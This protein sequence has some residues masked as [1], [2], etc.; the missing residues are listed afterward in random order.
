ME[1]RTGMDRIN[2]EKERWNDHDSN[3][4]PS[5]SSRIVALSLFLSVTTMKSM[6]GGFSLSLQDGDNHR[7]ISRMTCILR[8]EKTRSDKTSCTE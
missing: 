5:F 3:N 7:C 6:F 2:R 8:K 4:G 1:K